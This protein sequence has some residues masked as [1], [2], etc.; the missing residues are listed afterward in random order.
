MRNY[1]IAA[2]AAFVISILTFGGSAEAA[3]CQNGSTAQ[4]CPPPKAVKWSGKSSDKFL[5]ECAWLPFPK[6]VRRPIIFLKQE[7]DD[8]CI[9]RNWRSACPECED[10]AIHGTRGRVNGPAKGA[11]IVWRLHNGQTGISVPRARLARIRND[12][13]WCDYG[14][15]GKYD[16]HHF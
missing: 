4:G 1:I 10:W 5:K 8:A 7:G 11:R 12:A 13:G 9:G 2:L 16:S 3:N 6:N 14:I 15:S